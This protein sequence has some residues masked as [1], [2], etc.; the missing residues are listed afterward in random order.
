M[1]IERNTFLLCFSAIIWKRVFSCLI[2][3]SEHKSIPIY[4]SNILKSLKYNLLAPSGFVNK[5][6]PFI[7]K[8]LLNNFL[9]PKDYED[10]IY[11]KNSIQLFSRAY[12]ITKMNNNDKEKEFIH[13][14]TSNAFLENA[15]N[16]Q[17][18]K[19][20]INDSVIDENIDDFCNLVDLWDIELGL[21][22][23]ED[24]YFNLM[25]LYLFSVLGC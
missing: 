18:A 24:P 15:E 5:L 21:V 8:T 6:K 12:K 20:L 11:V 23:S 25:K 14:Y 22:V 13:S 2:I 9:M 19:D 10:N 4:S 7:L 3:Y 1:D 16:E 17:E